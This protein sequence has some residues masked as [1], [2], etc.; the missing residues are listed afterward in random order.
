MT[1]PSS[2]RVVAPHIPK[3]PNEPCA[4]VTPAGRGWTASETT[5]VHLGSR[6]NK[7]EELNHNLG[8]S[9]H[10]RGPSCSQMSSEKSP[11]EGC[12]GV[13]MHRHCVEKGTD[14]QGPR[15]LLG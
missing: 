9:A 6:K 13:T 15:G 11:E 5:L 14:R 4:R 1:A 10:S 7:N 8:L 3:H 2:F 12:A